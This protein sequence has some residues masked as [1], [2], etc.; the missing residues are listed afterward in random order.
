MPSSVKVRDTGLR[1]YRERAERLSRGKSVTVGVHGDAG[2]GYETISVL[3]LAAI[4]EFGLGNSPERSFIRAWVEE[5]KD[6]IQQMIARMGEA[7]QAG[8]LAEGQALEQLG[9]W[10]QGNIQARISQGIPPPNAPSTAA[11][12]DSSTP[13]VD[14]GQLKSSITYKVGG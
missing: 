10:A 11:A 14:T 9:L 13:L 2:G 3:E 6:E 12:K 4:H 5:N 7:I 1:K 8:K